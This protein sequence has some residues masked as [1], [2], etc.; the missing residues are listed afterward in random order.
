MLRDLYRDSANF[1]TDIEE[2]TA[3]QYMLLGG[4]VASIDMLMSPEMQEAYKNAQADITDRKKSAL[5]LID[6]YVASVKSD[7]ELRQKI[8]DTFE[9]TVSEEEQ[10]V[11]DME[12][13]EA[14]V[15][16][17]TPEPEAA[18]EPVQI[19][20]EPETQ[21]TGTTV[22]PEP[23]NA[24]ESLKTTPEQTIQEPEGE[25]KPVVED[26]EDY[27]AQVAQIESEYAPSTN[28][29]FTTKDL[30]VDFGVAVE[31]WAKVDQQT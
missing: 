10:T 4:K 2:A 23:E 28:T 20:V 21:P 11:E 27:D 9:S 17:A 14:P 22:Q 12:T 19:P 7:E 30:D 5:N 25:I 18:P 24:S 6:R 29:M 26:T 1:V 16:E 15:E 8:H 13:E 3:V 31:D